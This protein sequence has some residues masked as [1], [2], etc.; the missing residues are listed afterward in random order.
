MQT[1]NF[2]KAYNE[3]RNGANFFLR[4]WANKKFQYSDGVRDCAEPGCYWLLDI[5][6]TELP[7]VFKAQAN[8]SSMAIIKVVSA[9]CCAKITAEFTDDVVAWEKAIEWTDFPEGT[10]LF[11]VTDESD[12]FAMILPSEY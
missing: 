8:V 2:I 7:A 9:L 1:E 10:W 5:L 12:R 11:Y 6:A 4:H 3:S